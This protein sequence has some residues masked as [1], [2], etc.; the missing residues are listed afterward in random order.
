MSTG[1]ACPRPDDVALASVA[2]SE[3]ASDSGVGGSPRDLVHCYY[4]KVLIALLRRDHVLGLPPV[5]AQRA[6][7]ASMVTT[8]RIPDPSMLLL[9]MS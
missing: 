7:H 6:A 9:F 2:S 4:M 1:G 8:S 5:A 3:L